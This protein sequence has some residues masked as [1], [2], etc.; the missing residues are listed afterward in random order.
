MN[1]FCSVKFVPFGRDDLEATVLLVQ[2]ERIAHALHDLGPGRSGG[3]LPW[4]AVSAGVRGI[5]PP[6]TCG[7]SA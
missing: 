6:F 3:S 7:W 1:W 2:E 5:M 4:P